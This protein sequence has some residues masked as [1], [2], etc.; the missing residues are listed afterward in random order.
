MQTPKQVPAKLIPEQEAVQP[1]QGNAALEIISPAQHQCLLGQL[2][3]CTATE[4]MFSGTEETAHAWYIY[5]S[6]T[7]AVQ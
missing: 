4:M 6:L 1:C 7:A 3:S 2:Q 5:S